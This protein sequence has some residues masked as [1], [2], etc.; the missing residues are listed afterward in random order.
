MFKSADEKTRATFQ[1]NVTQEILD[2]YKSSPKSNTAPAMLLDR[3]GIKANCITINKAKRYLFSMFRAGGFTPLLTD[4][5]SRPDETLL[6]DFDRH[7]SVILGGAWNMP[8]H[9]HA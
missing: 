2:L 6:D 9:A 8:R 7:G 4:E 3:C 1:A 5:Y